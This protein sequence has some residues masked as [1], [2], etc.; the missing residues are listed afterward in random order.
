[1][2]TTTPPLRHRLNSSD[3]GTP[4][5]GLGP[6]TDLL[7]PTALAGK[8]TR[9]TESSLMQHADT[10]YASAVS[11]LVGALLH[12]SVLPCESHQLYGKWARHLPCNASHKSAAYCCIH[13]HM[14]CPQVLT[15]TLWTVCLHSSTASNCTSM[16]CRFPVQELTCYIPKRGQAGSRRQAAPA[17]PLTPA[18]QPAASLTQTQQLCPQQAPRQSTCR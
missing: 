1:M 10:A 17:P 3:Q 4:E 9:L 15:R 13:C 14:T 12:C 7:S 6:L 5:P 11:C 18:C 16:W 8:V 2:S